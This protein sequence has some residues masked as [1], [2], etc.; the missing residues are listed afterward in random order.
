MEQIDTAEGHELIIRL[1]M[2]NN[3]K[4]LCENSKPMGIGAWKI[5]EILK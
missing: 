2:E 1:E 5:A 3:W 4:I